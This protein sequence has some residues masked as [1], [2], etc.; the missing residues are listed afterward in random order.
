L[1]FAYHSPPGSFN[2]MKTD[3]RRPGVIFD[4]RG[5]TGK[6]IRAKWMVRK[7]PVA[8]P[9]RGSREWGIVR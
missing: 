9:Q 5:E 2:R 8:T 4:G 1:I 6:E 3:L 7:D